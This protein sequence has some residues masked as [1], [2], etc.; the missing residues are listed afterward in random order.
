[1]DIDSINRANRGQI[2]QPIKGWANQRGTADP[3][4]DKVSLRR[5]RRAVT[6]GALAERGYLTLYCVRCH[7]LFTGNA[8]VERGSNC[9]HR[10][11]LPKLLDP[12]AIRHRS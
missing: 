1:M 3:I 11:L 10:S 5:D 6:S 8:R 7:L 9:R 4:I 12:P 2:A